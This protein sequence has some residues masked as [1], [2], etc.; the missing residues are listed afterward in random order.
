MKIAACLVGACAALFSLSARADGPALYKLDGAAS[1][2]TY[3]VVHKLH[4]VAGTF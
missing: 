1:S 4:V 2:I 3:K